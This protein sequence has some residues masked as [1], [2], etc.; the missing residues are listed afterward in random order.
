MVVAC[1]TCQI[2]LRNGGNGGLITKCWSFVVWYGRFHRI[3]LVGDS[4]IY[5]EIW[6]RTH[7][8]QEVVIARSAKFN[9]ELG[10]FHETSPYSLWFPCGFLVVSCNIC[11]ILQ[12]SARS[13]GIAISGSK[14]VPQNSENSVGR[15]PWRLQLHLRPMAP[16]PISAE[17]REP[18][19]RQLAGDESRKSLNWAT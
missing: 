3:F 8:V 18:G 1:Q 17:Q 16:C 14:K 15:A 4:E 9:E 5:P 11:K 19:A 6:E 2:N 7:I 13:V 12:D 10:R